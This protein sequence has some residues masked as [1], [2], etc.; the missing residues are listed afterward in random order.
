MS[1]QIPDAKVTG[2]GTVAA[3][4]YGT[5]TLNGA[6]T[7]T[8][9]VACHELK[10]N[11]AG[12]CSG[13]VKAD[14]ITVNGTGTFDG[15]VQAA[16]FVVN[17]TADV[18]SS[19]GAGVLRVKGTLTLDGGLAAREI[20]LRGEL[21]SGGDVTAER[22]FGEGRFRVAGNVEVADIDLRLQLKS[23]ANEITCQKMVLRVPE[24]ITAV[25]SAFSDRE[26]QV[27]S[28]NG[29]ELELIGTV[30]SVVKGSRVTLGEGCRV[31]RVEYT[32]VLQKL[33]GAL[34]TEEV[35]V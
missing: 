29:G 11:G 7:I 17:G 10:V 20:E 23:S 30:A 12:K 6:G 15:T 19:V 27:A 4:T 25:F 3:G 14:V 28:V 21:R 8:G 35:K 18:H 9:D 2:D 32:E 1:D 16:E 5:I 24:G 31:G 13:A 22:L 26:L 34:V 33:S